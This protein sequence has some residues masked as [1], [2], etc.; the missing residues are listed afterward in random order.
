MQM[1]R[2]T[3]PEKRVLCATDLSAG[4]QHAVARATRLAQQ[5]DAKLTLLHVIDPAELATHPLDARDE[6]A[7]QL[8]SI[9]MPMHGEPQI[10]VQTGNDVE[11]IAAV[12]KQI[13]ADIIV[14]GA[15]RRKAPAPLIG[16][17]AERI[18]AL[19]GRPALIVNLDARVRYG[20]VVIAAELSDAFIQVVRVAASM[21]FLDAGR[22]SI[23][24]GFEFSNR[25]PLYAD[26]FGLQAAKRNMEAW[27]RAARARLL[28]NLD[29]AG[30]ESSRFRL[31]FQQARPIRA[32]QRVMRSVRPELLI[33]GTKERSIFARTTRS[34]VGNDALR[35]IDCDI[36]VAAPQVETV[37]GDLNVNVAMQS[38]RIDLTVQEPR[39]S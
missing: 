28:L 19:A 39:L 1:T 12:A 22:V 13:D 3:A 21:K 10:L 38:M 31:I 15:Q 20:G 25:G 27:E 33:V 32:I 8:A 34:S 36:L 2:D 11:E 9:G 30:V 4:S 14:L 26:G 16:T 5:L 23:V 37:V 35:S 24:H 17:T 18:I 7:Q 6:V 29:A